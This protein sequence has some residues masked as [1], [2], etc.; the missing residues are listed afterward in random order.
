MTEL[1][2][3]T[4]V[5]EYTSIFTT[6]QSICTL[7]NNLWIFLMIWIR[8]PFRLGS[9]SHCIQPSVSKTSSDRLHLTDWTD[10][11]DVT[12]ATYQTTNYTTA[13]CSSWKPLY[14]KTCTVYIFTVDTQWITQT[15]IICGINVQITCLFF[16]SDGGL[17]HE[18]QS[19]PSL[20][21]F[22][23]VSE[24]NPLVVQTHAHPRASPSPPPI[25]HDLQQS[26][27]TSYVLLNLAKGK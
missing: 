17:S 6:K 12:S 26:D 13:L 21:E 19:S 24:R 20:S 8:I 18:H 16:S 23:G 2:K 4:T 22:G 14:I 11:C 3:L 15:L 9:L 27:S 1:W 10:I 25:L 7:G 5:V